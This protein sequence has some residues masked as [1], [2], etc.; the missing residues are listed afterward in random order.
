MDGTSFATNHAV[1]GSI[2]FAVRERLARLH[3]VQNFAGVKTRF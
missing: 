2:Q 1:I 3:S